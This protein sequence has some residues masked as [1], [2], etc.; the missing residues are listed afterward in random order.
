MARLEER[1]NDAT[2]AL[3]T[4]N[5]LAGRHDLSTAERDGAILRL[6]YTFEA[7]WKAA[8][9]LLE[10]SEGISVG[11]PKAAIRASRRA[12]L[13]DDEDTQDALQIA[14]D[15]NLAVHMYKQTL[16]EAVAER[17]ATH[18]AVLQRWLDALKQRASGSE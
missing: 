18:A 8:A 6:V 13:L 17:L 2:A 4:L 1:L 14:D 11:S 10:Q 9:L 16:G 3:A 5:E 15:R 7:L 12:H